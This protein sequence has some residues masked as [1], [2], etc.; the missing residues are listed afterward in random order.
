MNL[1]G[2]SVPF[3]PA[4]G[5][6]GSPPQGGFPGLGTTS[7][8]PTSPAY[9]PP[10]PTLAPAPGNV[11]SPPVNPYSPT[12][13]QQNFYASAPPPPQ[14]PSPPPVLTPVMIARAQKHCRFAISALDYE[15]A[16]QAKKELRAALAVLGE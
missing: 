10:P 7:G 3:S 11:Y 9:V 5:S 16:E 2:S 8:L 4:S 1:N 14:E 13:S 6:G 12:P 15:D